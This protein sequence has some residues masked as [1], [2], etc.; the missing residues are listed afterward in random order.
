MMALG[1]ELDELVN[2]PLS[3]GRDPFEWL[4]DELLAM[5]MLMMSGEVLWGLVCER[6]CQRWTRLV[7][8]ATVQRRKRKV[9]WTAYEM[10]TIKPRVLEGYSQGLTDS[11]VL[12][13]GVGMDGKLYSFS[14]NRGDWIQVWDTTNNYTELRVLK[15]HA[16]TVLALEVGL[17]DKVYSASTDCT[18]R[19]WSGDDS[20]HLNTLEGH[21][22]SVIALAVGLDGKV[23]S[24]SRDHTIRVWSGDDGT[25]LQTLEGHTRGVLA[26]AVG[27]N[28][29]IYSGSYDCDVRVWCGAYGTHLQTLAGHED[30]VCSLA[31]GLDGKVFSGSDD[32]TIWVWS[33][34]DGVH[35][36]TI[37]GHE[38]G[39]VILAVG[40][41]GNLYSG[42]QDGIRVWRGSDGALLHDLQNR[43]QVEKVESLVVLPDGTL[44]VG[45]SFVD[46]EYI[47]VGYLDSDEGAA[48]VGAIEVW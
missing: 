18:I 20:A 47:E 30:T 44:I 7:N 2:K 28:G 46:D 42:A 23:Y 29:K 10:Y 11:P 9:R 22:S 26:L 27:L 48:E 43:G 25:H 1:S 39:S 34:D 31:V 21:T 41:D 33:G 14:D 24:G 40:P 37:N 36:Q 5:I 15:G 45:G 19:V 8:S 35:L 3:G 32:G 4:P 16:D 12:A 6:V 13:L 38:G 17:D